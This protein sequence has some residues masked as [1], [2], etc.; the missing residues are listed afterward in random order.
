MLTQLPP[1]PQTFW[2]ILIFKNF[3]GFSNFKFGLARPQ[4][5]KP[6]RC[7]RPPPPSPQKQL[8]LLSPQ[9]R[10]NST[11]RSKDDRKRSKNKEVAKAR[12]AR[13][14]R[15]NHEWHP[16]LW[17]IFNTRLPVVFRARRRS[18]EG[19]VR[20]NGRPKG[21]F[22][23]VCFFSAPVKFALKT[24]EALSGKRRNGLSKT[25]SWT[26]VSPHDAFSAPLVHPGFLWCAIR[27]LAW[28]LCDVLQASPLF[29]SGSF[30]LF[31]AF[32]CTLLKGNKPRDS[33][34]RATIARYFPP[35]SSLLS[36]S[37]FWLVKFSAYSPGD[38]RAVS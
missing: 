3:W 4:F 10:W 8:S 35:C 20:G 32:L 22:W 28:S 16:F 17:R 33:G 5:H 24:L 14:A 13:A 19:V 23:R 25:P 11:G 18:G 26:T 1:T 30:E 21:C 9:D 38:K 6:R 31:L 7:L 37:I 15:S 12:E 34:K 27:A 29:L 2:P 36:C